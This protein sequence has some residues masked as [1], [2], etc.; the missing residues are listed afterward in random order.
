MLPESLPVPMLLA[1]LLEL[2]TR[3]G[4]ARGAASLLFRSLAE[5]LKSPRGSCACRNHFGQRSR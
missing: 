3:G 4:R 2:R 5:C 1:F